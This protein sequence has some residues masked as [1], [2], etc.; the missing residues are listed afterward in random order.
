MADNVIQTEALVDAGPRT[1]NFKA[2]V[3][4]TTTFS[5]STWFALVIVLASFTIFQNTKSQKSKSQIKSSLIED[6]WYSKV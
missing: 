2:E 3:E 1:D 6:D 5:N 4:T